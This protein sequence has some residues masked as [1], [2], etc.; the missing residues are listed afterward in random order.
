MASFSVWLTDLICCC[1][2]ASEQKKKW[3]ATGH[4]HPTVCM[5]VGK[6]TNKNAR[7]V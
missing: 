6:N 5:T 1:L 3:N 4:Y 7:W 2:F